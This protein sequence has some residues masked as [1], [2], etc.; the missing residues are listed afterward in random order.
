MHVVSQ[1]EDKAKEHD[2]SRVHRCC[3]R[4]VASTHVPLKINYCGYQPLS[5]T[6]CEIAIIRGKSVESPFNA[7]GYTNTY[8]DLN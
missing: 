7:L 8:V 6:I 1:D 4:H 5:G 3:S 2:I